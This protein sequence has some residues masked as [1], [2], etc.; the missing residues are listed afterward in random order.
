MGH[1]DLD[2]LPAGLDAE[3]QAIPFVREPRVEAEVA[4]EVAQAAE[5]GDEREPGAAAGGDVDAVGRVAVR[6]EQVDGAGVDEV[7]SAASA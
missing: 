5:A 1:V 3:A 6:V 2:Q 7:A 4:V